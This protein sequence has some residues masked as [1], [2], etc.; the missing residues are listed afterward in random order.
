MRLLRILG[1]LLEVYHGRDVSVKE[2]AKTIFRE[3]QGYFQNSHHFFLGD[4]SDFFSGDDCEAVFFKEA[5]IA[6]FEITFPQ[7]EQ[8]A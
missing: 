4:V 2:T 8:A 3:L 5:S 7:D 6:F 1:Y